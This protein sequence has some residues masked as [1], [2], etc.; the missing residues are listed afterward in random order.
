MNFADPLYIKTKVGHYCSARA[1]E[2]QSATECKKAGERLG[3]QWAQS[4]TGPNDF[5][6]CLYADDGRNTVYF[7]L[8]PNPKRSNPNPKISAICRTAGKICFLYVSSLLCRFKIG[9]IFMDSVLKLYLNIL[10]I[11]KLQ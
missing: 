11:I 10:F 8:S 5:P 6:A 7:N 1:N 9:V 3:L 2:I 4:W